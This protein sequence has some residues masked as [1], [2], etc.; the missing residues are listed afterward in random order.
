MHQQGKKEK[1]HA[2]G[3]QSIFIQTGNPQ[4]SFTI[5]EE[6]NVKIMASSLELATI[7]SNNV[8]SG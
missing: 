8:I 2:Y 4:S 6:H 5:T 7:F 1:Q 3:L